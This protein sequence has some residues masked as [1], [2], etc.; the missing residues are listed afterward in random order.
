[1]VNTAAS[2]SMDKKGAE[3]VD[4]EGVV[5]VIDAA[6]T[7]GVKRWIQLSMW[8]T[9]SPTRLPGYLRAT[10]HAK[11]AADDHLSRSDMN[12]TVVRP[13]WLTDEAPTGRI[14]VGNEVEEGSIG[15]DDLAAVLVATLDHPA[16]YHRVFEVTGGGLP[17]AGALDALK[18]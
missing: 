13:P 11:L 5:A 16:T 3:L 4:H 6:A 9:G 10:G 7:A 12:W 18:D 1:M 8:G 2:R 17:I 15:R 14:T